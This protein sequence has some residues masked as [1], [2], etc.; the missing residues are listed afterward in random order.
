MEGIVT[1]PRIA[2]QLCLVA[3]ASLL[4]PTARAASRTR[5]NVA[6]AILIANRFAWWELSDATAE[7]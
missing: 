3:A 1:G 6:K 4:P 5:S 7:W 2:L